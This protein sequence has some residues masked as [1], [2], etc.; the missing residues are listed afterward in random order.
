MNSPTSARTT[1]IAWTS[2]AICSFGFVEAAFGAAFAAILGDPHAQLRVSKVVICQTWAEAIIE[3]LGR[4]NRPIKTLYRPSESPTF[5][6]YAMRIRQE[7]TFGSGIL[8]HLAL[9]LAGANSLEWLDV[10][11]P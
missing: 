5:D 8:Q 2:L 4:R 6:S 9:D 1:H 10:I 7:S 3:Y 11:S